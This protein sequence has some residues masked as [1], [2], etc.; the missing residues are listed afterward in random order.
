[1]LFLKMK[2]NMSREHV[3]DIFM[4]I[5]FKAIDKR[6]KLTISSTRYNQVSVWIMGLG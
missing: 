2:M 5:F 4:Y 6:N 1:M 3:L